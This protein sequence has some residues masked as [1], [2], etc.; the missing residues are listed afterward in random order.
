M[1]SSASES[2]SKDQDADGRADA[3]L[4]NGRGRTLRRLRL[5]IILGMFLPAVGLV[6]VAAVHYQ[7]L[8]RQ[9]GRDIDSASRIAQE[10]ALKMLETNEMLL[11]RMLDLLGSETD[12]E[13]LAR[14]PE[15]HERLRA[16]ARELPQ[17]QGLFLHAADA[18]AL[19]NS[20]LY[21]PP[22]QID[23]SDREWFR[24]H[25]DTPGRNVF[26]TEQLISRTTGEA[27]FDM[28]RR[29]TLADGSFAGT[30]NVSLRPG[31][32]TAFY[33]EMTATFPNLSV[34]IFRHDGKVLARWPESSKDAGS[35][36]AT[37]PLLEQ[38]NDGAT[39]GTLKNTSLFDA[40]DAIVSFR[41]LNHYPLYVI[42]GID[43]GSILSVWIGRVSLLSAFVVPLALG[44]A[45]M[46]WLGLARTREELDAIH[47]LSAETARRQRAELAL[48][49]A[50]SEE[51]YK[52]ALETGGLGAWELHLQG[53]VMNCSA[54]YKEQLG[55]PVAGTL[56]YEQLLQCIYA[57]DRDRVA[58]GIAEAVERR[59]NYDCEYRVVWPDRTIRWIVARGRPLYDQLGA[60]QRIVGVTLDITDRKQHE[61]ELRES[62]RQ[63]DEFIATLSH[64][65]RN[66]LAPIK[67]ALN[68]LRLRT[69][70][71]P[72]VQS[73]QDILDRQV[74]HLVRLVDD[75]LE[76]SRI[77]N[78]SVELRRE[79][80]RL[81]SVIDNA[82]ETITPLL[83]A[84][85]HQVSVKLPDEALWLDG[86]PVRLVQIF[87]NLLNNAAKFTPRSGTIEI[88]ATRD[89][90]AVHVSVKDSGVGI[91]E[92]QLERIFGM[93]TRIPGSNGL[94]IG[95]ALARGLAEKHG[96]SIQAT[97]AGPGH[98]ATFTVRLPLVHAPP[99]HPSSNPDS[100]PLLRKRILIVD[101][102][103]DAAES[104]RM[105]FELLDVSV[106]VANNGQR[107]LDMFDSDHFDVVLLDIGMP[108]MDGYAVARAIRQ[109][110]NGA[111]VL[112]VALTGWG[113]EGDREK[114]RA[115]GFDH[116]LVKPADINVLQSLLSSLEERHAATAAQD[117]APD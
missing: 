3:V 57:D 114:A 74:K 34:A 30:V 12:A 111:D 108:G 14:G 97:S 113:Q 44:L 9:A 102:N 84:S 41:R 55:A 11:S 17:V 100:A 13:I 112:L 29:R 69:A 64:E 48:S 52:L 77:T 26:I 1:T 95:L 42:A 86:D 85:R 47:R 4:R 7:D 96:G 18:R 70:S 59:A 94:G 103:L 38:I 67:N 27:F 99:E 21:P 31:Y 60:P 68:V 115:A 88:A 81:D 54:T 71:D 62:D 89:A 40:A 2:A 51:L 93:F 23:Y 36:P 50:Q 58:R 83:K 109:R 82:I 104:L 25:R 66:P 101:D 49:R 78:G 98:G 24:A 106:R 72:R 19:N 65:L 5:V 43:R 53:N 8:F 6:S 107:A 22:R 79:H 37:H 28:S 91:P 10:H 76:V 92:E 116:H 20:V 63:K 117:D 87:T 61:A 46:A 90:D 110:K 39:R 80:V 73:V 45:W 35:I 15:I 56:T 105:L 75:L 33:Q 32:L 16:M